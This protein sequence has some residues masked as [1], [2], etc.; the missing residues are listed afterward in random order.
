MSENIIVVVFVGPDGQS[1]VAAW[2][3]GPAGY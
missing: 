3:S 1:V 2:V